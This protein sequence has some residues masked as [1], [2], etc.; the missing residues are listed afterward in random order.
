[1]MPTPDEV[2]ALVNGLRE[3][4][5]QSRG[6]RALLFQNAADALESL[7]PPAGMVTG[8]CICPEC[9]IRHGGSHVKDAG[10]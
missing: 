9:G 7:S 2:A 6:K 1:M 5:F 8:E 10:F 3:A 4:V